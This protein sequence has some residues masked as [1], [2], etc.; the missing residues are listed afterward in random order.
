MHLFY[1]SFETF[2]SDVLATLM[3]GAFLAFFFFFIREKLMPAPKIFGRWYLEQLTTKTS[4]APYKNMRLQYVL[5]LYSDGLKI[6]G[7]AEKI[8]ESS[9]NGDRSFTGVSRTRATVSG[10][11]EKNYLSKDRIFFHINEAGHGREFTTIYQLVA[12][13]ME[14]CPFGDDPKWKLSGSFYSTGADQEG[15]VTCQQDP[16]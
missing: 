13:N 15:L 12:R 1:T 6:E 4:Y 14:D 8:H 9:V 10:F 11:I 2:W 7:T 16:F 5:M 3:G